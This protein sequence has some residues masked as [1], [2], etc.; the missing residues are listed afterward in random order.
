MIAS[1]SFQDLFFVFVAFVFVA[2]FFVA[3][4]FVVVFFVVFFFWFG[5]DLPRFGWPCFA[6]QHV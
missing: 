1:S 4:F 5:A 6:T 2:F 3:F